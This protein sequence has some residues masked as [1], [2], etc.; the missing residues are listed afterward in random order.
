MDRA[1]EK[2]EIVKVCKVHGELTI[3][4]VLSQLLKSGNTYLRCK[5]CE[6]DC[7]KKWKKNNPEIAKEISRKNNLRSKQYYKKYRIKNKAALSEKN[8]KNYIKTKE[9]VLNRTKEYEE[10]HRKNITD[11][12]IKRLLRM[13]G[14]PKDFQ[15]PELIELKRAQVMLKRKIEELKCQTKNHSQNSGNT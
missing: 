3:D 4:S 10:N 6:Y 2:R 13:N 7:I 14:I 8:K 9:S 5:F 12:H 15:C 1:E 11:I